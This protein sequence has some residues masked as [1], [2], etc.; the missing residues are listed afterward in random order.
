MAYER[1][2]RIARPKRYGAMLGPYEHRLD[3]RKEHSWDPPRF[4]YRDCISQNDE[5]WAYEEFR[6]SSNLS[7]SDRW[8]ARNNSRRECEDRAEYQWLF[9]AR[10]MARWRKKDEERVEALLLKEKEKQDRE[11][12]RLR[13]EKMWE[14]DLVGLAAMGL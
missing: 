7:K 9:Y 12:R 4:L 6:H 8:K 10:S 11:E 13:V 5:D 2:T 14:E 3:T 1:D